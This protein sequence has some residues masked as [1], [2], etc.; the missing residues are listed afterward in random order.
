MRIWALKG[1][2]KE[3]EMLSNLLVFLLTVF[4][5][6]TG[7]DLFKASLRGTRHAF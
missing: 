2:G 4:V 6:V 7:K 3:C 5:A 1:N